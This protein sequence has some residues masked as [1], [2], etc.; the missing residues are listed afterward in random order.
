MKSTEELRM[1]C[2][3]A[4]I[5]ITKSEHFTAHN[6]KSDGCRCI[7]C[8]QMHVVKEIAEEIALWIGLVGE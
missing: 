2:V 8:Y 5:E 4:A 1:D 3:N 6:M 7:R